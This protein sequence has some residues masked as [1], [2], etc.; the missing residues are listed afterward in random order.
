MMRAVTTRGP[1]SASRRNAPPGKLSAA[2][3]ADFG[4]HVSVQRDGAGASRDGATALVRDVLS[5]PGR[6]LDAGT[7]AFMEPRF[8]HDFSAVRVH[9]DDIA[10]RSAQAIGAN[11]Y[12]AGTHVAFGAGLFA[13]SAQAG[14]RM[15]AH[16]LAHVVQQ[17]DAANRLPVQTALTLNDL[18]DTFEAAADRAAGQAIAAPAASSPVAAAT[19]RTNG[20][21]D[22]PGVVQR[23]AAPAQASGKG[24]EQAVDMMVPKAPLEAWDWIEPILETEL[25]FTWLELGPKASRQ[26]NSQIQSFFDQFDK[27]AK[28]DQKLSDIVNIAAGGGGNALQDKLSDYASLS[29]GIGG[30]IAQAVQV[31]LAHTLNTDKVSDAKTNAS[32][33]A[34]NI[35]SKEFVRTS[36]QFKQFDAEAKAKLELEFDKWWVW[37]GKADPRMNEPD[38]YIMTPIWRDRV[39]EE[40]GVDSAASLQILADLRA[41][42]VKILEPLRGPLKRS[43]RGRRLGIGSATGA[44]AG[45]LIGTAVGAGASG[46]NIGW[47]IAGGLIGA[48]GGALLGLAGG[49][50]ANLLSKDDKKDDK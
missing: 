35:E 14:Q 39:R 50:I 13:P 43:L 5:S 19:A 36:P 33:T 26:T 20:M 27:D 49:A 11:A 22:K 47:A 30:A 7:R 4:P 8:G 23:Q 24:D 2:R 12:T 32:E 29:G 37:Y 25:V 48:A 16:E 46:G 44:L 6:P 31:I 21:I 41:A 45:G 38:K 17:A 9:T 10:A 15:L 34:N 28:A 3:A 42:V 40:Y 1:E 18:G